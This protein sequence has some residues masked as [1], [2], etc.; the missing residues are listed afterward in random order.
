MTRAVTLVVRALTDEPE[1]V[2]DRGDEDDQG[3]GAC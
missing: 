1:D 3:V 2:P